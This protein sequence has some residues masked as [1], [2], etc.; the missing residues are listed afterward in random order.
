[1]KRFS[2]LVIGCVFFVAGILK[3]M[4]PLGS[5]LVMEAYFKFLHLGFLKPAAMVF[6]DIF[7]LFETSLGAALITGVWKKPV[8]LTT[9]AT[10]GF[11]TLLTL[12]LWIANP[13][14]DC[15]C[16]GQMIHLEHWQSF[17]KNV[18]LDLLW[19]AAFVPMPEENARKSKY[20][21]FG[22]AVLSSTAF[23]IYSS[24]SIPMLD[25]TPYAPGAELADG[26]SD[27][28]LTLS[29]CDSDW[30]YA[31]S[32]AIRGD[33][34][35]NSVYS[36]D[37]FDAED[38]ARLQSFGDMVRAEGMT[39]LI[40]A[41]SAPEETPSDSLEIFFADRKTLMTLNRSNGGATLLKDGQVVH[42]WSFLGLP[43]EAAMQEKTPRRLWLQGFL[44][45]VFSVML[46]L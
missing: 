45:Y 41:A 35:V 43:D 26:V 1:M 11:F 9:A 19:V 37:R 30:E 2:A 38:W 4:D 7:S 13:E 3:L 29:F 25:F 39:Q 27:S 44:L 32:L 12:I 34:I 20:A 33:V 17:V 15:G 40:L 46:L 10:L 24:L 28:E 5:S 36:P 16:F 8:A 23:L 14:M 18:V 6:S 21:A 42:K 22:I 31:D